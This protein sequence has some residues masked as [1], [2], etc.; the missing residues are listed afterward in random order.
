MWR[1]FVGV[2]GSA[3]LF[4]FGCGFD[5]AR[6]SSPEPDARP[7]TGPEDLPACPSGFVDLC[8]LEPTEQ[9]LVIGEGDPKTLDTDTNQA[10]VNLT[11]PDGS[12]VC[13]LYYRNVSISGSLV[14]YGGRPLAIA[15]A[16]HLQISGVVDVS[17]RRVPDDR[18]GAGSRRTACTFTGLPEASTGGGGGG[19]GGSFLSAGGTGGRGDRTAS[20]GGRPGT[21]LTA[22]PIALRGGCYGQRG[23][24][25]DTG[26]TGGD[27]GFGGG[28]IYLRGSTIDL[29]GQVLAVGAG[30][31]G[32]SS[33]RAGGGG[34]GAGGMIVV[35]G[36]GVNLSGLLLAT[37]GGGG[38]GGDNGNAGEDGAEAS[39]IAS[40]PGGTGRP[41]GG[42][43][44]QGAVNNPGTA[45]GDGNDSGGGG[46]GGTG[47]VLL[48]GPPPSI[49]AMIAPTA[50]LR[51][52]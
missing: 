32:G 14:A 23:A 17:S 25:G 37:G 8:G 33:N 39:S 21:P 3:V 26:S 16:E 2:V 49:N 4:S 41:A 27:G 50:E 22:A 7:D 1:A 40:A 5:G 51:L 34:G 11:Q 47:V 15:A 42:D 19:A 24:N 6:G 45:G 36:G 35:Q 38:E 9:T 30:G 10:C 46:G 13:L 44:G 52:R 28:A 43:G 20:D 29:S 18:P 12:S 31:A 48:L